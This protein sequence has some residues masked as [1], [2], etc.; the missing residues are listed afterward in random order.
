MLL[1]PVEP[2]HRLFRT[3]NEHLFVHLINCIP[4]ALQ[5]HTILGSLMD[6]NRTFEI[7]L[8]KI[9]QIIFKYIFT[10]VS[11]PKKKHFVSVID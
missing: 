10:F 5:Y 9:I 8:Q 1:P 11:L 2:N 3:L 7:F 6:R 4:V